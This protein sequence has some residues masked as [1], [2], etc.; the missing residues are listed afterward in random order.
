MFSSNLSTTPEDESPDKVPPA[1][2][3]RLLTLSD[4]VFAIAITLL[5]LSIGVPKVS[6]GLGAALRHQWP[7]Y[8]SYVESFLIIGVIWAQHH[9]MFHHIKRV[10]HT[11]LL[12][13][14]VFLMWVASVP[15]PTE[16]IGNYL[17]KP[18]PARTAMAIYAGTLVVGA[19]LF[20]LLVRYATWDKG[21][22]GDATDWEALHRIS[23][24]YLIGIPLYLL[25]FGL[26]FVDVWASLG[27]FIAI[28]LFYAVAPLIPWNLAWL[29]QSDDQSEVEAEAEGDG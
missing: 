29:G 27:L 22:T 11:F 8:L 12:L 6:N 1:G 20:N 18:G 7:Q 4:G 3:E 25:D 26:A 17:T 9:Q 15:F 24:S 5:V 19:L 16:L 14:I 10:D 28:A 21:L 23:Q 2:T 13:N